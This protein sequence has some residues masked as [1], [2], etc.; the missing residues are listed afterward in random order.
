MCRWQKCPKLKVLQVLSSIQPE[1]LDAQLCQSS[2]AK[3]RGFFLLAVS[4]DFRFKKQKQNKQNLNT[5]VWDRKGSCK[6]ANILEKWKDP[7]GTEN[8]GK[9]RLS[10]QQ[11]AEFLQVIK[12]N[13]ETPR[14]RCEARTK[15]KKLL[16]LTKMVTHIKELD[17][18]LAASNIRLMG[19]ISGW[20]PLYLDLYSFVP[21]HSN[22]LF[23]SPF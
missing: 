23:G 10:E 9:W 19:S 5:W 7:N 4:V 6:A 20:I 2:K 18:S 13:F 16:S 17:S 14:I 21:Y 11:F 8:G 3:S 12:I 1:S 22:T 15:N